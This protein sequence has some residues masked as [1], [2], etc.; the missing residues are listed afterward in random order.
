M[1]SYE[2]NPNAYFSTRAMHLFHELN[3]LYDGTVNQLHHFAFLSMD[4]TS[5]DVFTYHK[6]MH[7]ADAELFISAMQKEIFDH[8][9]RNHWTIVHRSTLPL[10]T[11]TI[12]AI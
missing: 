10:A 9:S 11:K 12:Q 8:G 2:L 3:E 7:E 1:P 5:N 4:V 6:A